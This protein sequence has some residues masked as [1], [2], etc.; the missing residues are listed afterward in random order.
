MTNPSYATRIST[1]ARV[2]RSSIILALDLTN[3][4]LPINKDLLEKIEC[5]ICAVKMNFHLLLSLSRIDISN[6][7]EKIHLYGLQSIADIKLSDI[8]STNK[9]TVQN[10]SRLKFDAVIVNPIM[11]LENL[12]SVIKYAHIFKMGVI[13]LVQ[14]SPFDKSIYHFRIFSEEGKKE[15]SIPLYEL[16][17]QYSIKSGADG[18]VVGG[19]HKQVLKRVS[20]IS[21]IPVYSP[22]IGV[23]GG[24]PVEALSNGSK[25]LIVGRS[26]FQSKDPGRESKKLKDISNSILGEN[27]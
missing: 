9:I 23:Q 7:N 15:D 20:T 11:G 2:K 19:T 13:C 18:I 5:N 4:K 25:Y 16:F 26:I 3:E 27:N 21:K 14:A 10:L 24:D 6:L 8:L 1:S 12:R 17:L 22:G